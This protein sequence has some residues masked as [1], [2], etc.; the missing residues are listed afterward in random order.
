MAG[1]LYADHKTA[2]DRVNTDIDHDR[3]L[4]FV[5]LRKGRKDRVVPVGPRAR[6]WLSRYVSEVRG[7]LLKGRP[8]LALFVGKRGTR[9]TRTRINER[10]RA[11]IVSAPTPPGTIPSP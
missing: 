7:T 6:Q 5:R 1:A 11:Y 9:I 4:L 2:L 8:S 3:H 10:L